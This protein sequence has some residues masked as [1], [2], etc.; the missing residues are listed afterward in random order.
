MSK[1]CDVCNKGSI[2]VTNISH[3][4][5]GGWAKRAPKTKH[6]SYAN[7]RPLKIY[8]NGESNATRIKIC[9]TCYKTIGKSS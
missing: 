1:V 4:Q 5:S 2:M 9:M 7:L 3:K 8:Y 6:R